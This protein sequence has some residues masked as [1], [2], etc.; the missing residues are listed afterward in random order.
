[1]SNTLPPPSLHQISPFPK[2]QRFKGSK[3]LPLGLEVPNLG[4]L[5]TQPVVDAVADADAARTLEGVVG[6]GAVG[7]E[8]AVRGAEDDG[9]G[10]EVGGVAAGVEG[11]GVGAHFVGCVGWVVRCLRTCGM[12]DVDVM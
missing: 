10:G 7:G 1:M 11:V 5:V 2:V 12:V 8:Q 9:R 6:A 3:V 4:A